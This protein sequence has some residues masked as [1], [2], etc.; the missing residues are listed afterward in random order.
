MKQLCAYLNGEKIYDNV[1]L[2]HLNTFVIKEDFLQ[3]D[4]FGKYE[5][6]SGQFTDI[7]MWSRILNDDEIKQLYANQIMEDNPDVLDCEAATP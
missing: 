6:F 1:I 2:R 7:N 5:A 3:Y 4:M